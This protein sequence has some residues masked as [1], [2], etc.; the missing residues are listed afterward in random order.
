MRVRQHLAYAREPRTVLLGF[1]THSLRQ[2]RVRLDPQVHVEMFQGDGVVA[3]RRVDAALVIRRDR[4]ADRA[5]SRR[6]G[7]HAQ[8]LIPMSI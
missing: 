5:R 1:R 2:R 4:R 8:T 6:A 7:L 3:G